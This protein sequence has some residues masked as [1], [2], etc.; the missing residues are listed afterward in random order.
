MAGEHQGPVEPSSARITI[1][2]FQAWSRMVQPAMQGLP[3][4]GLG[5]ARWKGGVFRP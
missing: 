4:W 2:C 5:H 3:E 1:S